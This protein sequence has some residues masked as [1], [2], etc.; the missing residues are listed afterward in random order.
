MAERRRD[1]LAN[2]F[3]RVVEVGSGTGLNFAHYPRSVAQVLAVE[4]DRHMLRRSREAAARA[5]VPVQLERGFAEE[6]PVGDGWADFV[7]TTLVLCSVPW[8]ADALAEA[9]RVLKPGG[10]LLFLEHVR[11]NSPRLARWQDRLERPWGFFGGGCHPN[12]D[13][14]GTILDAGFRLEELERF[15]MPGLPLVRP[16]AVGVARN[17]TASA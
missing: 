4:P 1:L 11:S 6:V 17:D 15:P 5:P 10:R 16:H 8:P 13:T 7:V 14:V 12:R 9:R 2:A 3:G